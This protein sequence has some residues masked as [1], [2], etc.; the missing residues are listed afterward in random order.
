MSKLSNT[1]Y[2]Q[3]SELN[4]KINETTQKNNADKLEIW[5]SI[6]VVIIL[7]SA[8][9]FFV[10]SIINNVEPIIFI[11]VTIVMLLSGFTFYRLLMTV[12]DIYKEVQANCKRK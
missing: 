4:T 7:I 11:P 5:A 6:N 2:E 9:A 1:N 3:N 8:L 12:V 10:Y